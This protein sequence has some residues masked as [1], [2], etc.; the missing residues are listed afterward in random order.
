MEEKKKMCCFL[1]SAGEALVV[2][3]AK[4][5]KKKKNKEKNEENK[6]KENK[7]SLDRKLS[8]LTN[9]LW[10]GSFL[11][12]IEHIWHGEV[13]PFFPFI[14]AMSNKDDMKEMF[15]EMG[16]VGV[17]MALTITIVWALICL[18][19]DKVYKKE[20]VKETR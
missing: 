7:I 5:I 8:W 6:E 18:I 16:T 11:L 17:T 9:M 2:S 19:V 10:G 13:V 20:E 1:V 4:A 15:Y 3:G 14:T 12:L